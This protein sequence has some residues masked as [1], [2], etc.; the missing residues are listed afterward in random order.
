MDVEAED[1]SGLKIVPVGRPIEAR[2]DLSARPLHSCLPVSAG[3][4]GIGSEEWRGGM[5]K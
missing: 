1:V 2:A 3:N 4:E 5:E